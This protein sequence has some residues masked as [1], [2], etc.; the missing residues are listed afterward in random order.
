[1]S[2]VNNIKPIVVIDVDG[3]V[4]PLYDEW[5]KWYKE[6]TGKSPIN[7]HLYDMRSKMP[8]IDPFIF[9]NENPTIYD[10]ISPYYE[11]IGAIKSL[12]EYFDIVFATAYV[13]KIHAE[14]KMRFLDKY[15]PYHSGILFSDNKSQVD[16]FVLIDDHSINIEQW[17]KVKKIGLN[18]GNDPSRAWNKIH[19][20]V[21][22]ISENI[23]L[24]WKSVD[25]YNL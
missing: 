12:S 4:A 6:K 16:G 15:F 11:S 2:Y 8:L 17:E 14:S 18:I 25:S 22:L 3:T 21:L 13:S 23:A 20:D 5:A 1:M 9:L 10:K 24:Y 7:E 19:N